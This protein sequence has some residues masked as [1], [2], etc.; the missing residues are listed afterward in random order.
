MV[1]EMGRIVP[2][3]RQLYEKTVSELKMELQVALVDWSHKSA[4]HLLLQD[5]S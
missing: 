5:G 2:S 3:F 1:L 4:F